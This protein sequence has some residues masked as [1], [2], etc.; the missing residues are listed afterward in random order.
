MAQENN[1][2][3]GAIVLLLVITIL[4][5]DLTSNNNDNIEEIWHQECLDVSD[6]DSDGD[7]DSEADKQCQDYPYIDGS[8]E[9]ATQNIFPGG[10][11]GYEP[12]NDFI[13]YADYSYNQSALPNGYPGTIEDWKCDLVIMG[14]TKYITSYD[15]TFG[16]SED[17][18]VNNHM[19][20]CQAN[21][22]GILNNKNQQPPA[23]PE[24]PEEEPEEEQEPL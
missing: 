18:K 4:G 7:Y 3:T 5:I 2:F 14:A 9:N 21:N 20:E 6:N 17:N 1:M 24:E 16:T 11:S 15:S 10:E 12:F 19:M 8:G 13:K 22:N 23:E